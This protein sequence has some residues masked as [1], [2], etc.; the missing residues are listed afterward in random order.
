MLNK[1]FDCIDLNWNF[2][3]YYSFYILLFI[4]FY[5]IFNK[6]FNKIITKYNI[7]IIYKNIILI[8]NKG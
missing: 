7:Y 3:F 1:H 2:N 5:L 6:N 4:N 8:K